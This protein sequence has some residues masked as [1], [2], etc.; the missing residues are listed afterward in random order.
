MQ[1]HSQKLFLLMWPQVTILSPAHCGLDLGPELFLWTNVAD[2]NKYLRLLL[3][4]WCPLSPPLSNSLGRKVAEQEQCR[5]VRCS[6][7]LAKAAFH[8]HW[9]QRKLVE[10]SLLRLM[11]AFVI[12][13]LGS[14]FNHWRKTENHPWV[15]PAWVLETL[16]LLVECTGEW[17]LKALEKWVVWILP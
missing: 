16:C 8:L 14:P 12:I 1:N 13:A 2:V 9:L 7:T 5:A 15:T 6:E 3:I 11:L 17:L 10:T 4:K